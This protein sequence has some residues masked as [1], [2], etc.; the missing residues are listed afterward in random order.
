MAIDTRQKRH[1]CLAQRFG[2]LPFG[3]RFLAPIPDGTIDQGDRQHTGVAY[4]GLAASS[5]QVGAYLLGSIVIIPFLSGEVSSHPIFS[6]SIL[7]LPQA[8]GEV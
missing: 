7:V 5:P 8:T 2:R 3:R 4:A 1:S 6:G